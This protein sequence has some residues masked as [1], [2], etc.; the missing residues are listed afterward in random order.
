MSDTQ[1]A[2]TL[3]TGRARRGDPSTA[4]LAGAAVDVPRRCAQVLAVLKRE[5]PFALTAADV[6]RELCSE[7]EW[8]AEKNVV[9]RRLLDLERRALAVRVGERVGNQGRLVTE[10]RAA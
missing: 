2:L 9:S 10:W 1:L 8:W 5:T 3:D 4:V 7:G 6:S